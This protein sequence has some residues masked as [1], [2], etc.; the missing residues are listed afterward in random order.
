MFN[1]L[2]AAAAA[3]MTPSRTPASD[4]EQNP[5]RI[6]LEPYPSFQGDVNAMLLQS[7]AH[8]PSTSTDPNRARTPSAYYGRIQ[9]PRAS[10]PSGFCAETPSTPTHQNRSRIRTQNTPAETPSTFRLE[11]P[12]SSHYNRVPT[13][14]TA[15]ASPSTH[16]AK[17][18][19]IFHYRAE[20]PDTLSSYQS[21][22]ETPS[23]INRRSHSP[24]KWET[25]TIRLE[26]LESPLIDPNPLGIWETK[27]EFDEAEAHFP[28]STLHSL[29][30]MSRPDRCL[31]LAHLPVPTFHAYRHALHLNPPSPFT[32]PLPLSTLSRPSSST[33]NPSLLQLA[34]MTS[35]ILG[36]AVSPSNHVR[37]TTYAT[38]MLLQRVLARV[39]SPE[40]M[41]AHEAALPTLHPLLKA[42]LTV[43]VLANAPHTDETFDAMRD[44][45][46][47]VKELLALVMGAGD[48]EMKRYKR[49]R[50]GLGKRVKE[51]VREAA[52]SE[53]GRV[54]WEIQVWK[55]AVEER[56]EG[57]AVLRVEASGRE[58]GKADDS[59][60]AGEEGESVDGAD[61]ADDAGDVTGSD[62]KEGGLEELE[63]S[64]LERLWC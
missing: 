11:T 35:L 24:S 4:S 48:D 30:Q 14:S 33:T 3:K 1:R 25:S 52:M 44:V 32:T 16:R 62:G 21:R 22:V 29:A 5:Q 31:A 51:G 10:S 12:S 28:R 59:V 20:T 55:D 40:E 13:P 41:A 50:E 23:T 54:E 6:S 2:K 45:V 34:S 47:V 8:T 39:F 42:Q 43:I 61:D 64:V 7:L 15:R 46:D 60:D 53:E 49:M 63:N 19:S 56:K 17:T 38:P 18:P 27:A 37:T 9:A 58:G 57:Q 26:D 36:R